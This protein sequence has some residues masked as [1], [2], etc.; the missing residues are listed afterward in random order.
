MSLYVKDERTDGRTDERT[1]GRTDE[2]TKRRLY[3]SPSVSIINEDSNQ[4]IT[5]F[6]FATLFQEEVQ[7]HCK[8]KIS[9]S[10]TIIIEQTNLTK[11]IEAVYTQVRPLSHYSVLG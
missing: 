11:I 2:R 7:I 1:D 4:N 10:N 6:K 5:R 9:Q 8:T 3:A